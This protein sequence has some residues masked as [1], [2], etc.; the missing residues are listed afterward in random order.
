MKSSARLVYLG[1]A[2]GILWNLVG[3][4]KLFFKTLIPEQIIQFDKH[5]FQMGWFNHYLV[6]A[7]L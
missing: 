6:E 2:L 7:C 5:I 3:G 1:F 4:L